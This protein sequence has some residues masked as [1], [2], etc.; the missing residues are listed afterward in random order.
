MQMKSSLLL[1]VMVF[2]VA[3]GQVFGK[4]GEERYQV[5]TIVF[6]VVGAAA[7]IVL[8]MLVMDLTRKDFRTAQGTVASRHRNQ[9][10]VKL[11]SG[12]HQSCVIAADQK[13]ESFAAGDRV[14]L[15]LGR[16]SR[17][18]HRVTPLIQPEQTKLDMAAERFN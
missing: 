11:D 13:P 8:F 17:M 14:E 10:W 6:A 5:L 7:A 16:R 1:A 9:V 12:K 4:W 3:A 15:M 18:V 2:A